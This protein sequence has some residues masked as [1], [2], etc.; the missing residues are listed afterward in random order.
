MKEIA[1][2]HVVSMSLFGAAVM[3]VLINISQLFFRDIHASNIDN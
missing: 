3:F 1:E 2:L